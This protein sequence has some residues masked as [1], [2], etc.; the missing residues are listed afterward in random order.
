MDL[1]LS[2]V[3]AV[4]KR[5][6][7]LMAAALA[8]GIVLGRYVHIQLFYI[9]AAVV[10]TAAAVCFLRTRLIWFAAAVFLMAGAALSSAAFSVHPVETGKDQM[11]TGRV[12]TTPYENDYGSLVCLIDDASIDGQACGNIKLYA[13][14]DS[15]IKCGDVVSALA[16][17]QLPPGV[18]NPG[19][20]DERLHLLTQGVHYKA[21]AQTAEVTGTRISAKVVL[22]GLRTGLGE[23]ID[24]LFASDTAPIVQ[25]ML[26]GDKYGIDEQTYTAFRDSGMAHVLAVSGLHAGILIA[27]VYGLLSLLRLGRTPKLIAALVFIA[28]YACVAGLTPSILRASIMAVVLLVLRHM[29]RQSDTLSNLALAFILSLILNPLDLFTV[30]F[31]LSFGAVFGILTLGW[32][33]QRLLSK[34]LP[35]KLGGVVAVS[36]GATAGTLPVTAAAFNRVSLLGLVSN[37]VVLPLASLVIVLSF[38]TVALGLVIGQS[39]QYLGFAVDVVIRLMLGIIRALG[40]LPFAAV[41][42]ATPPWYLLLA[43]YGLLFVC[44]KYLLIKPWL[45]AAGGAALA[46]IVAAVMVVSRPPGMYMVFLDVGQGD[47]AFVRT[48]QGGAYFFDGGREQSAQEIVSFTIRQ[49]ITPD[50][51]FVSHTDSDHFAGLIALYEAGLL[52]KVY[53]AYQE[54]AAVA[55]AMPGAQVVPLGAGDTVLLDDVTKAVVLYPCK[56]AQT[57]TDINEMSLVLRIEY[58][59]YSVLLTGDISGITETELFCTENSVDIYKAAHHGSRYS[60][61]R[62][63]LCVL[64][65]AYSVVSVGGNAYGHPHPWAVQNLEDYSKRVLIT[66]DDYAIEFFL[67]EDIRLNTYGGK[68]YGG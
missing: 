43:S 2:R 52:G 51:A 13:P 23:T 1:A 22:E 27:A 34:W 47:A 11:V 28:V 46:V 54:E 50:A 49:G 45:K 9:T 33:L 40:A 38:I 44:S 53:C 26:I 30:G 57:G 8:A 67:H 39:A 59:T 35:V 48:E 7:V 5:P 41:D 58:G 15:G 6:V 17:T 66:Q 65:P 68:D 25:G 56:D 37:I 20:F 42:V 29:G 18:R 4:N 10:L 64:R 14:A 63:P 3:R 24:A 36:V 21:Y 61:Y 60:S 62:L 19:G 12:F 31:Q 16:D 55:A 32:Q